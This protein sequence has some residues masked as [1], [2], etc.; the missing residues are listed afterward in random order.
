MGYNQ[1][2]QPLVSTKCPIAPLSLPCLP[3]A[4]PWDL[5]QLARFFSCP[6]HCAMTLRQLPRFL[7]LDARNGN[8]SW[9]AHACVQTAPSLGEKNTSEIDSLKAN[10]ENKKSMFLSAN[11]SVAPKKRIQNL[12]GES[13]HHTTNNK[14]PRIGGRKPCSIGSIP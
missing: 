10:R 5:S 14:K 4:S 13:N 11:G 6:M 8:A 9:G 3:A 7:P 12:K 2:H 1:A